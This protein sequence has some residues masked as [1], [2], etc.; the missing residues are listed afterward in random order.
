MYVVQLCT[1]LDLA[2]FLFSFLF[3]SW[4]IAFRWEVVGNKGPSCLLLVHECEHTR[5]TLLT[6]IYIISKKKPKKR[7]TLCT[8]D[9]VHL[10]LLLSI[11]QTLFLSVFDLNPNPRATFILFFSTFLMKCQF[12]ILI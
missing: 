9:S 2:D 1:Y 12:T 8:Q 6:C 7:Y 4:H 3:F 11:T 5:S 10:S